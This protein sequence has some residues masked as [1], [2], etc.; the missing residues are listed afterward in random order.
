MPG[1][2]REISRRVLGRSRENVVHVFLF[3]V[4]KRRKISSKRKFWAGYPCRHLVKNFGHAVQILERKKRLCHGHPVR[5][6][7]TKFLSEKLR[8]VYLFP[9]N[10]SFKISTRMK[11]LFRIVEKITVTVV[12]GH[13]IKRLLQLQLRLF[14][15]EWI[16][17]RKQVLSGIFKVFIA[18]TVTG[19]NCLCISDVITKIIT[20]LIFIMANYFRQFHAF[21]V[22][23]REVQGESI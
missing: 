23:A 19:L 20:Y 12:R 6:S 10:I 13:L 14:S 3:L 15:D 16:Y 4:H 22:Y 5:A 2:C 21:L 9:I 7:M 18:I 8:V 1:Q 11:L 17:Y